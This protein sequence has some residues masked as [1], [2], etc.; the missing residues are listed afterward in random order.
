MTNDDILWYIVIGGIINF[1]IL[2]V[3]ISAATSNKKKNKYMEA[4]IE[5]L[6]RIASQIPMSKDEVEGMRNTLNHG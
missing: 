3:V 2:G 5:I 6:L 4:Q 1:I